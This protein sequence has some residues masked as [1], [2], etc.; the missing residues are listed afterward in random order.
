MGRVASSSLA[1]GT[2]E[3]T[4]QRPLVAVGVIIVKE[5]KILIG[6]RL[7]SHGAGTFSIPGGHFEF[8]KTFEEVARMEVRE[9]TGL[10]DILFKRIVSVNNERVYG[11]HYVNIG[12]LTEWKSGEPYAAEPEKSRNW[13]WYDPKEL[14]EP[15][16]A[17]SKGIIDAW[18]S[19]K[20]I[21]EIT[22]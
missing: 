4:K 10:T 12:F 13:K 22:A 16:F 2:M 21:N 9:E 17:P 7:A 19:G 8:G 3:K 14:P 6:E 5:G 20:L 15:M 18:L 11:K 1:L